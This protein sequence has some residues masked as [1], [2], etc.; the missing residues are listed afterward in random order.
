[1]RTLAE[2]G[3]E[4]RLHLRKAAEQRPTRQIEDTPEITFD[5]PDGITVQLQDVNYCGGTGRLGNICG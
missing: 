4:G 1:M 2:H 3:V 5:D